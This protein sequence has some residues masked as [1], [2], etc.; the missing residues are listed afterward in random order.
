VHYLIRKWQSTVAI[1]LRVFHFVCGVPGALMAV[2]CVLEQ[3]V[4][5][6]QDPHD[7]DSVDS[8]SRSALS[9]DAKF[10]AGKGPRCGAWRGLLLSARVSVCLVTT[11]Y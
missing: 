8:R 2:G 5:P 1:R 6:V 9:N 7:R 11:A 4:A 10:F 3:C